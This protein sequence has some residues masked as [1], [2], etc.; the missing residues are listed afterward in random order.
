MCIRDRDWSNVRDSAW[1]VS[2]PM[3]DGARL[4]Q[5]AAMVKAVN[6]RTHVWVYR[7]PP[8]DP[9]PSSSLPDPAAAGQATWSRR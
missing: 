3:D 8:L 9:R 7:A 5:Q 6:P 1:A 4:I 2:R